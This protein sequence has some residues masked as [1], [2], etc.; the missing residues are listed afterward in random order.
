[1]QLQRDLDQIE[2]TLPI[3][4]K[5]IYMDI[6]SNLTQIIVGSVFLNFL[7]YSQGIFISSMVTFMCCISLGARLWSKLQFYEEK[8]V[9]FIITI[10]RV[11]A[12]N[13]FG[14]GNNKHPKLT[15]SRSDITLLG[16]SPGYEFD[17]FWD[18]TG[19]QLNRGKVIM[20]PELFIYAESAKYSI[21]KLSTTELWW[22]GQELSEFLDLELQ[23][24]YPT[25]KVP[26]EP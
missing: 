26:P 14:L 22:I 7:L 9:K 16:Y 1:M 15:S 6:V 5:N 3:T 25:P 17:R 10:K 2:I 18:S 24:I 13:I 12:Y 11:N 21:T 23:I 4:Y 8:L 20:E 19:Q